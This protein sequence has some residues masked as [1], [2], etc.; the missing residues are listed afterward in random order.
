[1]T[2]TPPAPTVT[3]F[4]DADPCPRA[5]IVITPMPGDA[6]AITIY[7]TWQG[8]RAVVRGAEN[9]EVAGDHLVIDY[10]V[11]LGTPVAYSSVTYDV[12]AIP[13]EEST[14]TTTTV[15]VDDVWIQDAL[16]PGTA[17]QVGLTIPREVMCIFPSFL[18]A[19]YTMAVGISPIVGDPTPVG[20]G[21]TRQAASRVPFTIVATSTSAAGAVKELLD[22]AFPLCVRTPAAV[23]QFKGLLYLGIPEYSPDPHA[24]WDETTYAMVGD[25]IRGPGSGIVVQPRTFDDL[26][27]ESATFTGLMSLYATF[28]ELRRGL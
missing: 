6:D 25:S 8:Q 5:E 15:T 12:S 20:F 21:G 22:Q 19:S 13:S 24:G 27:D 23:P 1:V 16:D 26:L 18:P 9:A 14:A 10:E 28:L 17:I 3:V 4:T 7:R 11:P 2:T